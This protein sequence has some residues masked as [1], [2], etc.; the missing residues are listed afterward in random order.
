MRRTNP[1]SLTPELRIKA[2]RTIIEAKQ[3]G[4]PCI[5]YETAR[6]TA[7][8]EA[9]Y[10]QGREPPEAVNEKR[11]A[12]GLPVIGEAEAGRVITNFPASKH[13]GGYAVDIV[14]I[15]NG[16]PFWNA[17]TAVWEKLRAIAGKNGLQPGGGGYGQVYEKIQNSPHFELSTDKT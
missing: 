2:L 15:R 4:I 3:Q 17:D 7:A 8:Q 6:D 9:Y 16:L 10:A 1:N 12:A 5:I 13:T 11:Q 14:P